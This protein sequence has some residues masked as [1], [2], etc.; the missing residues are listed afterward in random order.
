MF[1]VEKLGLTAVEKE[2]VL[3]VLPD[4]YD[5]HENVPI[6]ARLFYHDTKHTI[7][8]VERTLKIVEAMGLPGHERQLAVIAAAN[9]DTMQ[10]WTSSGEELAVRRRN[11]GFNEFGSA[12][13]A[14]ATMHQS[15]EK[16]TF[17]PTD[18]GIVSAAIMV[19][20][21]S[22]DANAGTVVQS[23]LNPHSHPVVRAVALADIGSPGMDPTGFSNEGWN[24]FAE[25]QI[26]IMQILSGAASRSEVSGT[27][28]LAWRERLIKWLES[29]VGF[30]RGRQALLENELEGL[31]SD[32]KCTVAN[33][34][35]N[36]D[37]SIKKAQ[38]N[39]S[40]A[41]GVGFVPLMRK[42]LPGAFPD[43]Q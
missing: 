27:N 30:A 13:G 39:V 5:V 1:D 17:S 37:A 8:V 33:L 3:G 42:L 29:Q 9:H 21:P 31:E 43:D 26:G 18:V 14:I 25:E 16:P 20:I 19:T 7:G 22:W 38:E 36:F 12:L 40:F 2:I 10:D 23:F 11:A 35:C 32:A 28:Q 4:I 6:P 41:K 34:F 24:L 15:L